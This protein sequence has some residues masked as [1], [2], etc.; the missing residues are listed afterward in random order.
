MINLDITVNVVVAV[1]VKILY[2]GKTGRPESLT[3]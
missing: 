3:R 1:L 2:T